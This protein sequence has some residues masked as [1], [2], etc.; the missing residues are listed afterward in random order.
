MRAFA[1]AAPQA[2][3]VLTHTLRE[4]PGSHEIQK[5]GCTLLSLLAHDPKNVSIL[6]SEGGME[7][8][9]TIFSVSKKNPQLQPLAM[10]LLA[11]LM[12]DPNSSATVSPNLLIRAPIFAPS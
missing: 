11:V 9:Q 6:A 2:I 8:A 3:P 12:K 4:H 7:A 5:E 10:K 1:T